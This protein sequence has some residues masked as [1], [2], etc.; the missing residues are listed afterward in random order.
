MIKINFRFL[1]HVYDKRFLMSNAKYILPSKKISKFVHFFLW[2]IKW[3]ANSRCKYLCV[4]LITS[5]KYAFF[6]SADL[7]RYKSRIWTL[8][9][10]VPEYWRQNSVNYRLVSA[11]F[12]IV[13]C[14]WCSTNVRTKHKFLETITVTQIKR[15]VAKLNIKAPTIQRG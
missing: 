9:H 11:T 14:F 7:A 1:M 13:L 5:V 2:W 3:R 4:T 12:S 10:P 8:D 6:L 15:L